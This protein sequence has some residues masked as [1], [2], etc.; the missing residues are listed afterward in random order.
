MEAPHPAIS[1]IQAVL[2]GSFSARI[3]ASPTDVP[4]MIAEV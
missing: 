4:S 3:P 2:E 1:I